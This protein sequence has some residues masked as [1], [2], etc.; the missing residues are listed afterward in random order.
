MRTWIPWTLVV[1]LMATAGIAAVLGATSVPDAPSHNEFLSPFYTPEKS[2]TITDLPEAGYGGV[3]DFC[4]SGAL[5]GHVLY[6]GTDGRLV[7]S[8]LTAA[9]A[10]LPP[11]LPVYVD[12]SNN[13]IRGYIIASFKTDYMGTPNPS[14]V[15]MGRLAEMRGVEMVLESTSVPPV[16]FGRLEPC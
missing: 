4:A 12:W 16:V 3:E 1:A 13:F 15:N 9:I 2:V 10:G 8:V 14:S 11:N 5:S 7:P 6:N